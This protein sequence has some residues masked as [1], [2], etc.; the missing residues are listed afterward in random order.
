MKITENNGVVSGTLMYNFFEKDKNTGTIKGEMKGDLLVAEYS[1]HAEGMES[2][3]EVAFKKMGKN[4]IEGY[5]ESEEKDGKYVFINLDSLKF[6]NSVLLG[7]YD[8]EK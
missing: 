8:C 2:V 7:P 5:G 3:R 4:F 1:F 6:S